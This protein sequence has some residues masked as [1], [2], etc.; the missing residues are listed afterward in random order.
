[1]SK[2]DDTRLRI[3]ESASRI[4]SRDGLEGL[5]IGGLAATL[6]L[7]KSGLFAHFGSKEDLQ[8]EVLK[9]A[10]ARFEEVVLRPAFRAP[11]GEPRVR[12]LFT[13]WMRWV[14]DPSVPG[15]CLF[16]AAAT[17]LDDREGRP[18]DTLVGFQRELFAAIAKS[19]A[20]A[21]EEGHFRADLDSEQLA[22]ELYAILLGW[23]HAK[24]LLRDP[25]AEAR[26]NA[27]F[28]RL[29]AWAAAPPAVGRAR[30]S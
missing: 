25:K 21:I 13:A 29:M 4:A 22:F 12:R 3:L 2:G 23:N 26:T 5:S 30:K 17:E 28:E 9:A 8:V 1:M 14:V 10:A 11:R 6:G 24:R 18:R 7:S 20:I 19:A 16:V 15:G 27:A